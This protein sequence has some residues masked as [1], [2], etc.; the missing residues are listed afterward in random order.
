MNSQKIKEIVLDAI[1]RRPK[2]K[3]K[4]Y[5]ICWWENQIQCLSPHHTKE[6]HGIF[7]GA[8][9][10][11]FI[12][13]LSSYQLKLIEERIIAFCKSRKIQLHPKS[14]PQKTRGGKD[15]RKQKMQVTEFDSERLSTLITTTKVPGCSIENELVQ[16]Q[17]LLD[18]AEIVPPQNMPCDTVTMNSK[19]RLK[20]YRSNEDMVLSVVFPIDTDNDRTSEDLKVSI[21][22]PMGLS[23]FW[24][25]A[26]DAV[27]TKI[28]VEELLYQPEA[29]GDFHL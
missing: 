29:A 27:S 20:D 23:V 14:K 22:T 21:L 6:R 25:R 7:F 19:V 11:P 5:H 13:G 28:K 3:L 9:E 26:G 16:L 15:M 24:H 1:S 17:K 2:S 10:D 4:Y 8:S 18:D 12:K